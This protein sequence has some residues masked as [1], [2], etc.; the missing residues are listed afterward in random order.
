MGKNILSEEKGVALGIVMVMSVVLMAFCLTFLLISRTEVQDTQH[1]EAFVKGLPL[2]ETGIERAIWVLI[3]DDDIPDWDAPGTSTPTRMLYGCNDSNCPYKND[4]YSSLNKSHTTCKSTYNVKVEFCTGKLS[5]PSVGK[6]KFEMI[7]VINRLAQKW[8]WTGAGGDFDE[9]GDD[10]FVVG[11]KVGQMEFLPNETHDGNFI[12]FETIQEAWEDPHD[13]KGMSPAFDFNNDGHLDVITYEMRLDE[14]KFEEGERD[15]TKTVDYRL[16]TGNGDGTFNKMATFATTTNNESEDFWNRVISAGDIDNDGDIDI[17]VPDIDGKIRLYKNDGNG[18]FTLHDELAGWS[19][20]QWANTAG[21]GDFDG[22][23]DLDLIGGSVNDDKKYKLWENDGNGNF[24]EKPFGI[25]MPDYDNVSSPEEVYSDASGADCMLVADF[26]GDG[27]TDIVVGTDIWRADTEDDRENDFWGNGGK[28]YYFENLGGDFE[29]APV[30]TFRNSDG[31]FWSTRK[32]DGWV[33]RERRDGEWWYRY[34]NPYRFSIDL[35]SGGIADIDGDGYIDFMIGDTNNTGVIYFF[36]NMTTSGSGGGA[37]QIIKGLYRLTCT[38]ESQVRGRITTSR[39]VE[40]LVE[41]KANIGLQGSIGSLSELNYSGALSTDSY[42]SSVGH[43]TP[44]TNPD[45]EPNPHKKIN[46]NGNE[47]HI[48]SNEDI[49]LGGNVSIDGDA[50]CGAGKN[51]TI[52]GS[53]EISGSHKVA[54]KNIDLPLVKVPS[55][56]QD[57]GDIIGNTTLSTGTYSCRSIYIYNNE[58]LTINGTVILYCTGDIKIWG[59]VNTQN[60]NARATNFH[61][62]CTSGTTKIELKPQAFYGTIY[63]PETE[64]EFQGN[65]RIYGQLVGKKVSGGDSDNVWV[66]YDEQLKY[67]KL[68]YVS[69]VDRTAKIIYWREEKI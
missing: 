48:M 40:C 13:I 22:D 42:D 63:A 34:E 37:G 25:E 21:L 69:E 15:Y 50:T 51:I 26:D 45:G 57:I 66:I 5:A 49:I 32:D 67:I 14:D 39:K 54:T 7:E 36:R 43:Y 19:K 60:N 47:G 68:P 27:D 12:T 44:G 24:T 59:K 8:A 64:I 2:S 38:S 9:D 20:K 3:H 29:F 56:I 11:G 18:N 33:E 16:W 28:V 17:A 4:P 58:T 31:S 35:D 1:D 30:H 65:A 61:I 10:D 6:A 41:I 46:N 55:D 53:A 62:L 52:T 23:G